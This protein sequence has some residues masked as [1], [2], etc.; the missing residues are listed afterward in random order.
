[1]SDP[2]EDQGVKPGIAQGDFQPRTRRRVALDD[3]V[4]ILLNPFKY[5]S[6]STS[7]ISSL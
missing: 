5:H 2:V 4:Y 3:G 7:L 1:M 6:Q